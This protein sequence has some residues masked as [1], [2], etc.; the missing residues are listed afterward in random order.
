M[1]ARLERVRHDFDT[2]RIQRKRIATRLK[3]TTDKCLELEEE[4]VA[5]RTERNSLKLDARTSKNQEVL[6]K[7]KLEEIDVVL[8]TTLSEKKELVTE[9]R[10]LKKDLSLQE[11]E[12]SALTEAMER[13][14]Q[15]NRENTEYI[16]RLTSEN[17]ELR[18]SLSN[19]TDQRMKFEK[20]LV[21]KEE[22]YR[23]Q[24]DNTEESL[25]TLKF[26][27]AGETESLRVELEETKARNAELEEKLSVLQDEHT[28]LADN[29]TIVRKESEMT[30]RALEDRLISANVEKENEM[31]RLEARLAA[32][33]EEK[34]NKYREEVARVQESRRKDREMMSDIVTFS[35][36]LRDWRG[37]LFKVS[38]ELVG[39]VAK[40]Q[41][42]NE[43]ME[44]SVTCMSCM[45]TF[46]NPTAM[47]PCGHVACRNCIPSKCKECGMA[48]DGRATLAAVE[49]LISK[50]T[51]Q[52]QAMEALRRV[53]EESA[54]A[55]RDAKDLVLP[56]V[57]L[58][59]MDRESLSRRGS[60]RNINDLGSSRR[61]SGISSEGNELQRNSHESRRQSNASRETTDTGYGSE[62]T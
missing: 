54:A 21:E 56:S 61:T 35:S 40:M 16:E 59:T 15:T 45:D 39:T 33:Q 49:E 60:L 48:V 8:Q 7:T 53:A 14:K 28:Q 19:E 46:E 13:I 47:F 42:A 20:L 43:A 22:D 50:F 52:K 32:S 6:T 37:S 62:E 4:L 27:S 29:L 36:R 18:E 57:D 25:Q 17:T 26:S 1:A 23:R 51:Y 5:M 3:Q 10:S 34:I 11:G 12:N 24:L 30:A 31:K 55:A 58:A 2:L 41:H 38:E 9:I 44:S